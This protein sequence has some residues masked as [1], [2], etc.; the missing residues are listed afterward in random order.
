ML[1]MFDSFGLVYD[2]RVNSMHG[3]AECHA[4]SDNARRAGREKFQPAIKER[5]LA[6]T[7]MKKEC[8]AVARIAAS[9][10]HKELGVM[11]G[12][13]YDDDTAIAR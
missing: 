12:G 10:G 9:D 13:E 11:Y 3:C 1:N 8:L 7:A 6:Q 2:N 4:R 5:S